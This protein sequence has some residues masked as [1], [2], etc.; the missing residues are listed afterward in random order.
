MRNNRAS[1]SNPSSTLVRLFVERSAIEGSARLSPEEIMTRLIERTRRKRCRSLEQQIQFFLKDRNV[2]SSFEISPDLKCDGMI[3]PIGTT[4]AEGFTVNLRRGV[5]NVRSRFTLAHEACHTFFYE[6]VPEIKF[7]PHDA[8]ETEERLCNVGAATL[9]MPERSLRNRTS[10]L[11]VNL[12]SLQQLAD[13]YQ[14]SLPSMHLR[15]RDLGVWDCELSIWHRS[16]G[17]NFALDRLYGGNKAEWKWE[18]TSVLARTWE[19]KE[20]QFG[21]DFVYCVN[22]RG[23]RGCKPISYHIRRSLDGVTVLWGVGIKPSA[24]ARIPP[25]FSAAKDRSRAG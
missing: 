13:D 5:S 24:P 17:G 23:D 4:F 19:L 18:D 8:D 21:K 11:P 10:D 12:D 16:V 25:L 7:R 2:T 9:L 22:S 6:L 14:V 3:E 15:L 20:P 1:D